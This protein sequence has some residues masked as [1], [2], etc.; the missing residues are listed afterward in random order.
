MV[1]VASVSLAQLLG[2][3]RRPLVVKKKPRGVR[4]GLQH[5][6]RWWERRCAVKVN[7]RFWLNYV[8]HVLE[9]LIKQLQFGCRMPQKPQQEVVALPGADFVEA[10]NFCN[11][12]RGQ[13]C[14][15]LPVSLT[16]DI[17]RVQHPEP[18]L[19]CAF[20]A[21]ENARKVRIG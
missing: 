15:V 5:P 10:W 11:F 17:Y 4:L 14:S 7:R 18:S 2:K 6:E 21:V 13:T 19:L 9:N 3:Q 20:K 1:V 12:G 16:H 8:H